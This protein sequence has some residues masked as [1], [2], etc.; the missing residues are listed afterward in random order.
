VPILVVTTETR[1]TDVARA[2]RAGATGIVHKPAPVE[3]IMSE[4]RRLCATVP[5]EPTA[6]ATTPGADGADQPVRVR[7]GS[8]TFRRFE[9]FRPPNAAPQLVCPSCDRR[10]D[11]QNSRVGGVTDRFAEQWDRYVC[12]GTCGT[13]EYR[14]RT[15]K[16]RSLAS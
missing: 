5:P 4:V 10:L 8:K 9:T 12:P 3:S 11:Y 6:A 7:W 14:H 15:R 1:V 2:R 16:L 13:F